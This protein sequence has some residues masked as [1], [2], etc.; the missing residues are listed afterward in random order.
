M[1]ISDQ[2]PLSAAEE[3]FEAVEQELPIVG[4]EPRGPPGVGREEMH[5][6]SDPVDTV[7]DSKMLKEVFLLA[8]PEPFSNNIK[9]ELHSP[10]ESEQLSPESVP[11][12]QKLTHSRR[13]PTQS[14]AVKVFSHYVIG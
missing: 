4:E 2:P 8:T 6:S 11:P 12:L 13:S 1:Q 10:V 5:S 14:F 7:G 9:P 3:D